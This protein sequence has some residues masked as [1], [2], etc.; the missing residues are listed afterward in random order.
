M[1]NIAINKP[2]N[3]QPNGT[4]NPAEEIIQVSWSTAGAVQTAYALEIKDNSDNT[5]KYTLEKTTSYDTFYNLAENTL[6]N[7]K[8]YK[9]IIQVWDEEDYTS[10]SESVIFK[11]SARP[12]VTVDSI[13]TVTTQANTFSAIYTQSQS[14]PV[15]SW[16]AYL[17]DSNQHYLKDSDL[18]TDSILEYLFNYLQSGESYYI[19]F[20]ATSN[21]GLTATS[22]LI[23]FD[24][25][26]VQPSI[27][28]RLTAEN[29]DTCGIKLDWSVIQI[30]GKAENPETPIYID[31]NKVDLT[32]P[33]SKVYFDEGFSVDR[34]F[35]L[36]IWLENPDINKDLLLLKG[37]NGE[38]RLKYDILHETFILY[39]NVY[40]VSFEDTWI[41][42]QVNSGNYFICIKQCNTNMSITALENQ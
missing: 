20:Q 32:N 39:K 10:T 33:D 35:T 13:E 22:G 34:N 23:P 31:N 16:V 21:D 14:V 40:E 28:V 36:K 5:V 9:L 24:V 19:E 3:I 38:I 12:S 11:T 26:Y 41:S 42:E 15:R 18:Q 4:A 37:Q 29:N 27:N 1:I 8:E 2:F 7:G 25:N 30:I 6:E 17:Y